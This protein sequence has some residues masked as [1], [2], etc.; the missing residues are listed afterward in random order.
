MTSLPA[1]RLGLRDRGLLRKGY[2]ADIVI[3]DPETVLDRATFEDPLQYPVGVESVIV[4]GEVT[5]ENGATTGVRSGIVL[6][7]RCSG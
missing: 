3:F 2:F 1:Q 7:H 4:N 5:V 6:R